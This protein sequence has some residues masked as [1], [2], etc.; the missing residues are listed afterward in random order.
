MACYGDDEL[1]NA[2]TSHMLGAEGL[3]NAAAAANSMK[4]VCLCVE[5]LTPDRGGKPIFRIY[6]SLM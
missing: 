5:L 4:R 2:F 6:L 1:V 3:A